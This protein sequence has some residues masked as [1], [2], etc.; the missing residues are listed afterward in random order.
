MRGHL[1]A[2][3]CYNEKLFPLANPVEPRWI[4]SLYPCQEITPYTRGMLLR[5]GDLKGLPLTLGAYPNIGK[6][7]PYTRGKFCDR[8]MCRWFISEKMSFPQQEA[9]KKRKR[10][11]K[12]ENKRRDKKKW[13]YENEDENLKGQEK[14]GWKW[15]NNASTRWVVILGN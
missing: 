9:W 1:S 10:G 5:D 6:D 3:L 11:K 4:P 7:Q 15:E 14:S 8:E 2:T 13:N 12:W